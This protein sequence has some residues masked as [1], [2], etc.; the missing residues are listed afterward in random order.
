MSARKSDK[1]QSGGQ[2]D[3]FGTLHTLPDGFR[4]QRELITP[5]EEAEL[6]AQLRTLPFRAFDFQGYLANRQVV[7]FGHRYDYEHRGLVEAPAIPDFLL[8]LR[9]RVA[10]LAG[11]S[12]AAFVQVLVSEYQP[13]A[14]IGWHRDKPDFAE[15]A[16]VSLLASCSFRLRRKNGHTWDRETIIAEPRS[17]YLMEGRARDEWEHS[18]PPVAEQR[19]SITLRTMRPAMAR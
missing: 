12:A 18:I 13:G 14:G 10:A 19:Y 8:P 16:G 1:T 11:F 17:V 7:S 15:I 9:D 5:D 4:Y 2:D 3:L 6:V